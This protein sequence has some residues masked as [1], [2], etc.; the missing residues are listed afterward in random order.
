[1]KLQH[2]QIPPLT[3]N[4]NALNPDE[5]VEADTVALVQSGVLS[6]VPIAPRVIVEFRT[7]PED[8]VGPIAQ[9]WR[10]AGQL[11]PWRRETGTWYGLLAL[12]HTL[13]ILMGWVRW[14]FMRF[15]GY[16]FVPE[17][18][19]YARLEPGF[20]LSN[21]VGMVAVFITILLVATSANWAINLLGASAWKWLQYGAYSVSYLVVL[22]TFYFLFMH[23]TI[24]FHRRV[25]DDLNW[26]RYPF[27]ILTLIIPVLQLSAFIRVVVRRSNRSNKVQNVQSR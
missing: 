19:R 2:N 14:D 24:S 1:M 17:L 13:L 9:H 7:N 20:G 4:E 27:L 25:P 26:F 16:E 6:P 11:L 12:G 18:A 10:L 21:V 23:Y 5:T 15:F 8:N 22:H 3:L